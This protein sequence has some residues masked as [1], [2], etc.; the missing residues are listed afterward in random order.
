MMMKIVPSQGF[1]KIEHLRESGWKVIEIL[2]VD[3]L[4]D[5]QYNYV[6]LRFE[7]LDEA[8]DYVRDAMSL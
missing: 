7:D 2:D 3:D 4:M 5:G 8:K 1:Y 6:E